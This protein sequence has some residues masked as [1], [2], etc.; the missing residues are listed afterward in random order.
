MGPNLIFDKSALQALSMDEA[1]WLEAFF[2]T[3]VVPVFYVETL[4]DLEKEVKAGRTPEDLV[5][6]LATKTPA[7]AAPNVHHRELVLA[8]LAGLFD[9]ALDGRPLIR[10]GDLKRAPDGSVGF[11]V[12]EFPEQTALLRWRDHEFFEVERGTARDWRVELARADPSRQVETVKNVLPAPKISNLEELKA[13][14][15][16]FC[17]SDDLQVLL[18]ALEVLEVPQELIE[19]LRGRWERMGKP[20]LGEFAP[21][22]THVFKVELLFYLGLHRGFISDQRPSNRA[23][24]A[25]LYYLPFTNVFVSGDRLHHATAPLFLADSQTYLTRD[26]LKDSL[27]ELDR[28]YSGL[29]NAVKELGVMAFA[30]Y[31]PAG[32]ENAVGRVWDSCMGPGWRDSARAREKEVR[33]PDF[34]AQ[35]RPIPDDVRAKMDGARPIAREAGAPAP[36][37][38]DYMAITRRVPAQ[39]GKWRIVSREVADEGFDSL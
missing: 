14:I 15:D 6:M 38:A 31:P 24:I 27:G 21:F 30:S 29:P 5:G 33:E 12:G 20:P 3:N 10:S 13:F 35:R 4:A 26:E 36:D 7:N 37:D 17:V 18:L 39:K 9:L 8:D 28:Y 2:N 34:G 25:Y 1:V 32:I 16:D 19:P 22:A 23:D 11:H